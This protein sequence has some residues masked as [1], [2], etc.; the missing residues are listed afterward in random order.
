VFAWQRRRGRALG[1]RDGQSGAVTFVQRFGGALN[2]NPHLHSLLPD[3]LFVPE[4]EE[5]E[6]L[7]FV[8]L[9]APTTAEVEELTGKIARRLTRLVERLLEDECETAAALERVVAALREALAAAV[10]PPLPRPGLG[11]PGVDL[12][13][14]G[15]PLCARVAGFSLHAA[16]VI[17]AGDRAG[18][19][20]LCRYGLRAPFA[21]ER[22]SR[23]GDGR[24][25][26]HLRRPWPKADG[27]TCLVLEPVDLLR[28]L[29]A[30][31]PAPY[32]HMVRYHGIFANRSRWRARLP[33]PP[34]AGAGEETA[35]REEAA[36]RDPVPQEG[37]GARA[38]L[39]TP[40]LPERPPRRVLPWAKL[41]LRVFFL[42]VL[43]CP[44]CSTAMVVLAFLSDPPV[45]KRILRHLGLPDEALP[46]APAGHVHRDEPLF[47]ECA[48][49]DATSRS[50]P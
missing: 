27:A 12:E 46:L 9:P 48:A 11:L 41:L 15:T 8:P 33:A 38:E 3:G 26:Y 24:V 2:L 42:D 19:E 25:V 29:A 34:W 13:S 4:G 30:L 32:S 14:P 35:G 22:L 23:R 16:H 10:E 36:A 7:A 21:G 1:I 28:R 39:P 6:R 49:G 47:A 18:L 5:G 43:S 31:V 17:D 45:V 44:R 37:E 40:E 50:P 20:R